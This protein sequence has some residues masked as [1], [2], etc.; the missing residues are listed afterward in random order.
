MGT[1]K[2]IRKAQGLLKNV[3]CVSPKTYISHRIIAHIIII[4]SELEKLLIPLDNSTKSS[5]RKCR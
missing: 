4:N 1:R 3:G 2:T 5:W